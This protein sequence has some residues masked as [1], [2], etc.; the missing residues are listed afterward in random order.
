MT[1]KSAR[2]IVAAYIQNKVIVDDGS[3]SN[4]WPTAYMITDAILAALEAGGFAVVPKEPGDNVRK[5]MYATWDSFGDDAT[6]GPREAVAL[7][8]A[9]LAASNP[10]EE[11]R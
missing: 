2:E 1:D 11:G 9:A 5:A 10:K 3:W 7:Y 4:G 6:M 8:R